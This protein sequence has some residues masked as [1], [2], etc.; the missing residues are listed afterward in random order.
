M[1]DKDS[2]FK[3]ID[4][5]RKEGGGS[6]EESSKLK[7]KI[8]SEPPEQTPAPLE[9]GGKGDTPS[10]PA[11][12]G[13]AR[14]PWWAPWRYLS[15]GMALLAG[16]AIATL[17]CKFLDFDGGEVSQI[18]N[19]VFECNPMLECNCQAASQPDQPM[20]VAPEDE[21]QT[22]SGLQTEVTADQEESSAESEE[23]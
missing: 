23:D 17:A 20:P 14:H 15:P 7:P 1:S 9:G 10:T 8:D 22:L 6:D 5:G 11:A 3:I 12:S 2:L 13:N 19:P 21:A 16:I 18:C 4:G